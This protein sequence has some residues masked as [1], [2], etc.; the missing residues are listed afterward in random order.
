M[1]KILITFLMLLMVTPGLACGPFL[2]AAKA[3]AA[4]VSMPGMPDCKGMGMDSQK[5][6]RN[7]GDHVFFKDCA[8]VDL[9]GVDHANLKAPDL[10]GKVFFVAL[11]ATT[12]DYSVPPP[13]ANA[14]RGPP[15]DWPGLSETQPSILLTTQRFRE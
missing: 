6:A 9:S 8:K 1:R 4:Q 7:G 3:Q 11:L 13:A 10:S 5:K 15:P 2:G 14:I 12:P